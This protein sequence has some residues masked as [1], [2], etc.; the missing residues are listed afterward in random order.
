M[1]ATRS[2]S[3]KRTR[4]KVR[5]RR[6]IGEFDAKNP[7]NF[8]R[9]VKEAFDSLLAALNG[10]EAAMAALGIVN[11]NVTPS[12]LLPVRPELEFRGPGVE[13]SLTKQRYVATI[14]GGVTDH[15]ALTGLGDNDHTQYAN[16]A[17]GYDGV[18]STLAGQT[19]TTR[20]DQTTISITTSGAFNDWAPAGGWRTTRVLLFNPNGFTL[21][22]GFDA[23]SG[24]NDTLERECWNTS[25]STE[26]DIS[27]DSASNSSNSSRVL[28]PDN[29][30]FTVRPRAG[31]CMRW[32]T[33]A[34]RWRITATS[35]DH[36]RLNG[37][38]DDDHTQ[39]ILVAGTRAFTGDQS[40]GT[41]ELTSV[42]GI[43][44]TSG[45]AITMSA[46]DIT[47]FD[48]LVAD[49]SGSSINMASGTIFNVAYQEFE[50]GL[51]GAGTPSSNNMYFGTRFGLPYYRMGHKGLHKY[52]ACFDYQEAKST[53]VALS[54][55]TIDFA[56][57]DGG[58]NFTD[59][60]WH[61]ELFA[62]ETD[63]ASGTSS[64]LEWRIFKV[65]F[66]SGASTSVTVTEQQFDESG[67]TGS[68]SSTSPL[69]Y[70]SVTASGQVVT[71]TRN[72][73]FGSSINLLHYVL[74]T[75]I[76]R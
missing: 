53:G 60:A 6:Q 28:C 56:N 34:Q 22:N 13:L 67:V 52:P 51:T 42:G 63:V 58:R 29:Q 32:D 38:T 61:L 24:A 9:Q 54:N 23:P 57:I 27:H 33:I 20:R 30:A 55:F 70:G 2:N 16:A 59:G 14:A 69:T 49:G 3:G 48:D 44:M 76:S 7:A 75:G 41:H 45:A 25:T 50:D 64:H 62:Y 39:Y 37:L 4:Q 46:G 71:I 8:A 40:M 65:T 26:F 1:T 10:D 36:G 47:G 19:V 15:G 72:Y 21:V 17:V 35:Q 43:T 11:G 73:P 18:S 5:L 31:W 12:R 66:V 74:V 68:F